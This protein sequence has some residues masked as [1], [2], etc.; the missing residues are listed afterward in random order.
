MLPAR[1]GERE[2]ITDPRN[3]GCLLSAAEGYLELDMP[4]HALASLKQIDDPD[5]MLFKANFLRGEALRALDR[6]AEA[7]DSFARAFAQ[8]PDHVDLLMAMAWCYKRIDRID[9]S[10]ESMRQAYQFHPQAP[11]VL[12]NLACYYSLAGIKDQALSFLGRALR[13]N[14][15]IGKLVP[16]ETDFDT[17]RNDPDFKH[18]LELSSE[19]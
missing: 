6:H 14:R 1:A 8:D 2:Q 13:M 16:D 15:S 19:E 4:R 18:L 11:I 5:Q 9:Q 7:L 10:I 3:L 12:Y 17:L